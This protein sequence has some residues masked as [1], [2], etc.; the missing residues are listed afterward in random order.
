MKKKLA[1]ISGAGT[2]VICLIMNFF[3]IPKIEAGT[4][5]VRCFDM[6]FLYG[7]ETAREFLRLLTADGRRTYLNI[8]LPLD[9][10]YPVF[11]CVFF[12]L[13]IY[14]LSKGKKGLLVFPALLAVADYAENVCVEI[15]LRSSEPSDLLLTFASAATTVKTALMYITILIVIVLLIKYLVQKRKAKAQQ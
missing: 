13:M 1:V 4:N 15:I 10:I 6:N 2:A 14:M 8:Q 12:C 7:N 3:L 5:G 9:F 11:Y